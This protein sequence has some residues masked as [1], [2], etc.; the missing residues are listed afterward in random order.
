[1][2]GRKEVLAFL[3]DHMSSTSI[4]AAVVSDGGMD[5]KDEKVRSASMIFEQLAAVDSLLVSFYMQ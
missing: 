1:M 2:N 5:T 4:A 3:V